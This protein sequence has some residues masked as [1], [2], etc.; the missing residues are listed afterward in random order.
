MNNLKKKRLSLLLACALLG[1][2]A[3]QAQD[4]GELKKKI[5]PWLQRVE[6]QPDWLVSRLQMYWHSQ[7]T[8]VMV[9]GE[10]FQKPGGERAVVPTVKFNGTRGTASDY[11]R[12]R[13]EDIVPYDDDAEG[14]V[15]YINR[16]TGQMEKTHPS[17]TGCNIAGV[18]RQILDIA[19]DAAKIYELT[20]E[21]PYADMALPVLT[22]FLRGILHRNVPVDLNHGQMQTLVGMTTFEV[23]HEDAV[24][25]SCVTY[26]MLRPLMSGDDRQ[27]CEAALKKWAENI[28]ANGVPHNNWNLYQADF[29]VQ[30]ALAL[31]PDSAYADHR[32]RDHYLN[33]VVNESGIRQ[34]SMKEL[35][36]FGFDP[37]AHTWYESP[38]YSLGVVGT[39]V[40][41][42]DRLDEQ[43][44]IDLFQQMPILVDAVRRLPEYLFPNRMI[45][46]F[47]DTHPNYI[48]SNV[49]APV[50]RYARRHGN[51]QLI[52]EMEALQQALQPEAP[53]SVVSPYVHR[54]FHA[55]NVSWLVQRS[56]M[57]RQHDLMVSLNASLGNH[58]HANGLSAEFYGKGYVLGPDAGI[59]MH[60]YSGFDYLEYYSQM[61]SHN[62]VVV[63]GV[64]SYPAMMS[65][66]AFE[67]VNTA[68]FANGQS[69][70]VLA[71]REPETNAAQQRTTGIVRTLA[72]G[73]Y[74][75]DIFR[76]RRHNGR[77]RMHEYFYH[78]LGQQLAVCNPQ[79]HP[80]DM[81]PTEETAFAGGHLYAYSYIYNKECARQSGVVKASFLTRLEQPI[82]GYAST[83]GM[84]LW[85]LPQE[86][87]TVTKALS[88]VNLEYERMPRQP[89]KIKEQPVLTFIARQEG[90]AWNR[91]FVAVYEPSTCDEPAEILSV[92]GFKPKS[93]D[94][95]A[96]GI[97]VTLKS[98]RIDYIFSSATG[99]RMRHGRMKV[100]GYYV[101]VSQER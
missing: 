70:S 69:H 85:M 59:G 78:N 27:A 75:V 100:K 9:H 101:V 87:R 49:A 74:Y 91:P 94:L 47:G 66:H 93:N 11:N 77:D 45:A 16:S 95:A 1:A 3:L 50:I 88:P 96:V 34:W 41:F 39:F 37:V 2:A 4:A 68:S 61:P 8:D 10:T 54:V 12:P 58:Q 21:R 6:R 98:G 17:K 7:A 83:I 80:L 71:F 84:D 38:G 24:V 79:G 86:G 18:N 67:V 63:D 48:S 90:E 65:Q 57:D 81:Q 23:I 72:T 33:Y 36:A 32:G 73:G 31:Q 20:G 60:L 89:Y 64:S 76:S 53:A 5:D 25:S 43:A 40:A 82:E 52:A 15:T 46:G 28:I 55:P 42:A 35:A 99:A 62:T 22:T 19:R 44:G 26:R 92:E 56:G 51:R 97:K 30:I 14:C 29:I 13:L